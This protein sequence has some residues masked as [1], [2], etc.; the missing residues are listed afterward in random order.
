M[1]PAADDADDGDSEGKPERRAARPPCARCDLVDP[2][3]VGTEMPPATAA[4]TRVSDVDAEVLRDAAKAGRVAL[5]DRAELP[6]AAVA[7]ELAEDH[8][9]LGGGVLGEVVAGDLAVVGLVDDA[10]EGVAHLA[11]VLLPGLGVV[12][13]RPGRRSCRRRPARRRG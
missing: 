2:G 3:R 13:A 10:D 5:A 6:L 7:V 11:E 9:R 1:I 12:D 8:R 4:K